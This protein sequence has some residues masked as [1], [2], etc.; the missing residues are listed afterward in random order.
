MKE[1][2]SSGEMDRTGFDKDS[3]L[4]LEDL[5]SERAE[6]GLTIFEI[7]IYYDEGTIK[8]SS[9]AEL[10]QNDIEGFRDDPYRISVSAHGSRETESDESQARRGKIWKSAYVDIWKSSTKFRLHGEDRTWVLGKKATLLDF[11]KDQRNRDYKEFAF[12]TLTAVVYFVLFYFMAIRRVIEDPLTTIFAW[13]LLSGFLFYVY[14]SYV[15]KRSS[16]IRLLK[17]R[18]RKLDTHLLVAIVGVVFSIVIPILIAV[19]DS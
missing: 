16:R 13:V 15:S 11:L 14:F 18:R 19:F 8:I 10:E 7:N 4:K 1:F 6:T 5:L 17:K 3:L 12:L 2:H 9:F